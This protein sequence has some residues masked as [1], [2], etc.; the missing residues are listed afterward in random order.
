M[1][2]HCRNVI[3]L[4]QY[5]VVC[6]YYNT[7]SQIVSV[8]LVA[9][10][11]CPFMDT[12]TVVASWKVIPIST[13]RTIIFWYFL[14]LTK[15]LWLQKNWNSPLFI[16]NHYS[17]LK[18]AST[19]LAILTNS[20][21]VIINCICFWPFLVFS[22]TLNGCQCPLLLHLIHAPSSQSAAQPPFMPLPHSLQVC[23]FLF[24]F[25]LCSATQAPNVLF[26]CRLWLINSEYVSNFR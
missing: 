9:A 12:H 11:L 3:V 6:S 8:T 14:S 5:V 16:S 1:T 25:T 4:S 23:S 22:S 18:Q 2:V 19:R 10:K 13:F 21:P 17:Y 24:L 20:S 26:F 15:H 7:H